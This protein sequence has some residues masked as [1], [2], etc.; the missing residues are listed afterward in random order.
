MRTSL[1]HGALAIVAVAF[2]ASCQNSPGP[3]AAPA[4]ETYGVLPAAA[5][6]TVG[7]GTTFAA[8]YDG[9]PA[10]AVV[11]RVLEPAGGTVDG[12]GRYLA[13]D[14]PGLYTVQAR[15]KYSADR[16]ATAMVT[17]VAPPAGHITAPSDVLP[18]AG[19]LVASIA[20]V[21]GSHYAWT[22]TGG[23]LTAGS[24]SQAVTFQA[25]PGPKLV[26]RCRVT[27]AAG[28]VLNISREVRTAGAVS[29]AISPAEVTITTGRTMKFG[30]NVAGGTSLGVT[31]SLGESGAGRL[32]SLGNYQ[33]PDVPGRYTVRATSL[34]NPAVAVTARVQV[35]PKPPEGLTAPDSFR[36]GALDL[37]AQVPEVAG[38]T[39]AWAIEGGT[40]L[41]GATASAVTIHAGQGPSLTLRC[42]VT[43]QAGDSSATKKTLN[44]E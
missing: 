26:L 14:L 44:A 35:V 5:T 8:K 27:N 25:G 23:Q 18:G 12:A 37:R 21:P 42:R 43:N 41:S 31:W 40:I 16:T 3:M 15:F 30:F 32:D 38:M 22:I 28:D 39:Y 20:P 9:G 34:D 19:G 17:V 1:S 11:W 24:D 7:G 6:L 4:A 33:A 13:P 29:L 2:L 10:L 36:P